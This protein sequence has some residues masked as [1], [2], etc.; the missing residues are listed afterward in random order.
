MDDRTP[1]EEIAD[2]LRKD[3]AI[4]IILVIDKTEG[5]IHSNFKDDLHISRAT[6]TKRLEKAESLGLIE[7]SRQPED[8]GNA[9]RYVLTEE[10]RMLR[11]A[12]ES[13]GLPEKYQQ[14]IQLQRELDQSTEEVVDWV[15]DTPELWKEKLVNEVSFGEG[16]HTEDTFPGD[17]VPDGYISYI[18]KGLST[19]QKLNRMTVRNWRK[20]DNQSN[21]EEIENPSE[22]KAEEESDE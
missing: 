21:P 1:E 18:E 17:D 4:E 14:Y 2:F 13:M 15:I 5:T 11:V 16:L 10:G 8:H 22:G 12:V 9:K 6:V 7:Q 19:V 20:K 3:G